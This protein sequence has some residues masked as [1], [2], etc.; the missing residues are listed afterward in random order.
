M[1][2]T[3]KKR[4]NDNRPTERGAALVTVLLVATLLLAA[5]GALLLTTSMAG[6]LAVDST[7][8]GQAYY[9]AEAGVNSTLNVLRGA[10]PSNPAGTPTTFR[11][12]A[13]NPTLTNW[14]NYDGNMDG[15]SVVTL[16]TSPNLGYTVTL[17]D[18][19][20]TPPANQ[21]TRLLVHVTGYGPKGA[22]KQMEVMVKRYIFDF[23]TIAAVLTRGDD[24]NTTPMPT[25]DI[26]NSNAKAYSGYD[27]ANPA[28]SLPVFGST[29]ATDYNLTASQVDSSKDQTISGVQK[30]A[31]FTNSQLPNFLQTANNARSFLASVQSSAVGMGRS[32]SSAPANDIGTSSNP[33][34]TFVDG[35]AVLDSGAGTGTGAGILVVTGTLTL[36]GNIDFDGLILVLGEGTVVRN[37]GGGGSIYGGIVVAKF[38]RSSGGFLAPTYNDNGS[39]NSTVQY[40][41]AAIDRALSAAGCRVLALREY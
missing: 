36:N 5:G 8:E 18:P 16:G 41:S 20:S 34:L 19:D 4:N 38:D 1:K 10:V 22:K 11:N 28:V 33:Q 2:L 15:T 17:S 23:S 27:H 32:F 12:A 26:G 31:Q 29:N 14:L 37:G 9:S 21:P 39:G 3:S 35:N 13:D 6:T 40:D 25:F 7:A 30:E 24:D